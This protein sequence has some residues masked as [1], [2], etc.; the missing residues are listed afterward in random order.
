MVETIKTNI[1][2]INND[3]AI[4]IPTIVLPK[5][6][7]Q[8]IHKEI[9]RTGK[10]YTIP[11]NY[12]GMVRHYTDGRTFITIKHAPNI[13]TVEAI[14]EILGLNPLKPIQIRLYGTSE[15]INAH[16][17]HG[18]YGRVYI[19]KKLVNRTDLTKYDFYPIRV[20]GYLPDTYKIITIYR[21]IRKV[22][23]KYLENIYPTEKYKKDSYRWVIPKNL[24][25]IKPIETAFKLGYRP[26]IECLQDGEFIYVNFLFTG[27]EI[28]IIKELGDKIFRTSQ[29]L[30]ISLSTKRDYYF[31]LDIKSYYLSVCPKTFILDP[32][33]KIITIGEGEAW[34]NRNIFNR[35]F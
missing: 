24:Y 8:E 28:K 25:C 21:Y 26:Q 12:V 20:R 17:E 10:A 35:H 1:Y 6:E 23:I 32:N 16:K 33:G 13:G 14:S 11:D 19:K 7:I 5:P 31:T 22:V 2:K 27:Y 15:W 3:Y 4:N 34:T 18:V 29:T 9:K 30:N